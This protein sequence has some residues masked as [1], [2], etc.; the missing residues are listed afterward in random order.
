MTTRSYIGRTRNSGI[1]YPRVLSTAL[2]HHNYPPSR[3]LWVSSFGVLSPSF[4]KGL[5]L[6]RHTECL[7]AKQPYFYLVANHSVVL[8]FSFIRINKYNRAHLNVLSNSPRE[9][10]V[11]PD[12][13]LVYFTLRYHLSQRNIFIMARVTG[14]LL[15]C[16]T[17]PHASAKL[18]IM[19]RI[20]S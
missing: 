9:L 17:Q 5:L 1:R 7:K 8:F 15:V 18:Q 11:S 10:Q 13:L 12:F 16:G 2:L 3:G 14:S 20:G 19:G 6:L 4:P